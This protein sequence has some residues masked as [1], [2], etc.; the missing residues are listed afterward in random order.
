MLLP[1]EWPKGVLRRTGRPARAGRRARWAAV[2]IEF[3]IVVPLLAFVAVVAVDF[4]RVFYFT[5]T[6]WNCARQGA[7]YGSDALAAQH[8]PYANLTSAALADAANLSPPPVISSSTGT[9]GAGN[10]VISVTAGGTFSMVAHY[11]GVGHSFALSRTVQMRITPT[12]PK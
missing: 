9:D 12:L 11:P 8:S 1:T 2:A 7:L 6:L 10:A 5:M 3:A 4:A